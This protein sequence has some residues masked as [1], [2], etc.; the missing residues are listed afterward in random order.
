MKFFAPRKSGKS[1]LL[2]S[3]LSLTL[4]A[5]VAAM[6]MAAGNERDRNSIA[7]MIPQHS[8]G[9]VMLDTPW[10]YQNVVN[11][12]DEQG[13]S[14]LN[15][16]KEFQQFEKDHNISIEKDIMSWA[17]RIGFCLISIKEIEPT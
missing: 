12:K 9:F 8:V 10:W 4:L 16:N 11:V 13:N 5:V 7:T 1:W 17:G 14:L 2:V 6:T 15:N 3:A